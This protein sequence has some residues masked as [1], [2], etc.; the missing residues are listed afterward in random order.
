MSRE[1]LKTALS[2]VT[3]ENYSPYLNGPKHTFSLQFE[4]KMN[5]LIRQEKRPL[6]RFTNTPAKR[7]ALAVLIC[8]LMLTGL[9]SVSA[10]A[11]DA[12]VH[13][14]H[15]IGSG[16]IN[17]DY[18]ADTSGPIDHAVHFRAIPEGLTEVS[19]QKS[20]VSVRITYQDVTGNTI[21]I[22]QMLNP[23]LTVDTEFHA[24][25]QCTVGGKTVDLYLPTSS[26]PRYISTIAV[27]SLDQYTIKMN[28][29]GSISEEQILSWIALIE[30]EK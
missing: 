17:Y 20:A 9:F 21:K 15:L 16:H 11:R 14:V 12:V 10:K 6:W 30:L 8:M 26:D 13:L 27:W 29:D 28:I 4:E 19:Y 18:D 22:S 23:A 25:K 24:L 5:R 7:L 2:I 3:K 1:N